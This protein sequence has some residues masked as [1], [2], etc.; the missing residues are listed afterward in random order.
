MD[1][2]LISLGKFGL[3]TQLLIKT[4]FGFLTIAKT[5]GKHSTVLKEKE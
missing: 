3:N 4:S 2:S 1:K 5:P